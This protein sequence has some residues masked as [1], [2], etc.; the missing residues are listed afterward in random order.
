MSTSPKLIPPALLGASDRWMG[1]DSDCAAAGRSD[2][3]RSSS[4]R[5][6][7]SAESTG[8]A[9]GAATGVPDE[10]GGDSC[11]RSISPKSPNEAEF[12]PGVARATGWG[13]G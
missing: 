12:E 10:L 3:G 13:V 11:G 4:S 2:R 9:L 1:G 8:G 7:K 6:P 5:S